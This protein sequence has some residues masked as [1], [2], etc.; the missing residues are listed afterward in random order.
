MKFHIP[1]V[2]MINTE[3]KIKIMR[4]LMFHASPMSE[5]E[6]ASVVGVS[7]MSVNRTLKELSEH[8]LVTFV[9]TGKAH[10]WKLN[11]ESYSY[12]ALSGIIEKI[13][14]LDT[15]LNNLLAEIKR[16]I[17][18]KSAVK[19]VLFGSVARGTEEA[20]SDIDL[21]VLVKNVR[22]KSG[23]T[24]AVDRLSVKCLTV[25]GNKLSAYILTE[26][27]YGEKKNSGIAGEISKGI[28]II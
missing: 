28:S 6:I 25:Y 17:P 19:A 1:P 13:S 16:G 26:K 18:A 2:A 5:R 10:L 3:I 15:P 7:H 14:M 4:H 24:A 21:F 22:D 23:I 8:N 9:R 12:K 11:R 20:G 27:E